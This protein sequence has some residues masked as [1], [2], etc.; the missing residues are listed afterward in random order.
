MSDKKQG[1][2]PKDYKTEIV[3]YR[4]NKELKKKFTDDPQRN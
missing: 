1:R 4:I 3:G 2:P